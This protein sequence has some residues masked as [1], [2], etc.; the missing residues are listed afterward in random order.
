MS[1]FLKLTN[2]FN[3]IPINIPAGSFTVI[4]KLT[5]KLTWKCEAPGMAKTTLEKDKVG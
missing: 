4:G 3:V 2:G 5:R 1:I